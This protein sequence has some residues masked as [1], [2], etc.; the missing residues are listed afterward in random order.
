MQNS[1]ADTLITTG[2]FESNHACLTAFVTSMLD[3]KPVLVLM[4]PKERRELTFNEMLLRRLNTEVRYIYF[5]EDDRD[6][7]S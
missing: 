2:S 7:L 3:M 4:G 5:D 6:G 1:G